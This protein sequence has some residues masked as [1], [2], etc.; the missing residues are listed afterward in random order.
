MCAQD[1]AF[2]CLCLWYG[3]TVCSEIAL[4]LITS[5]RSYNSYLQNLGLLTQLSFWLD[6]YLRRIR[7]VGIKIWREFWYTKQGAPSKT[8]THFLTKLLT[9]S[10]LI[11]Q[12]RK[13]F[14]KNVKFCPA[15]EWTAPLIWKWSWIFGMQWWMI[16]A[17]QRT[18]LFM[19][20]QLL[21]QTRNVYTYALIQILVNT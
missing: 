15:R 9:A 13:K 8:P 5:Q 1:T 18:L 3:K 16:F 2:Q 6:S 19:W 11:F 20:K 4:V 10:G 17:L 12:V 7:R 21:L 14:I